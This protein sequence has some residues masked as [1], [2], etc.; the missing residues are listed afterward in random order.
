[1][2]V[3]TKLKRKETNMRESELPAWNDVTVWKDFKPPYTSKDVWAEYI[4]H[5]M[6]AH[7]TRWSYSCVENQHKHRYVHGSV[8]STSAVLFC[9]FRLQSIWWDFFYDIHFFHL[10]VFINIF[11]WWHF[12]ILHATVLKCELSPMELFIK[13]LVRS[14]DR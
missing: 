1:V 14:D 5:M 8:T 6:F 2:I 10:L 3:G 7:F 11:N 13:T 4:Q 9:L 12:F